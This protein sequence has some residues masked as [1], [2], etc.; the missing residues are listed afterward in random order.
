MFRRKFI[1]N[2]TKEQIIAL[3]TDAGRAALAAAMASPWQRD[4]ERRMKEQREAKF[5]S[6]LKT[7]QKK[8][9]IS[10]RNINWSSSELKY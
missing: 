10:A 7:A 2:Y 8:P 4:F 1:S 5:R 6:E 9:K 3:S